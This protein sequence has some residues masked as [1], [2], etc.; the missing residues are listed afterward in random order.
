MAFLSLSLFD[1]LGLAPLM[2][3]L[4]WWP[5]DF[6][7]SFS[8]WDTSWNAWNCPSGSVIVDRGLIQQYEVS[9]SRTLNDILTLAIYSDNPTNQSFYQFHDLDTELWPSPN[10]KWFQ[11]SVCS[12]CGMSVGNA[13]PFRI[14]GSVS[15]FGTCLWMRLVFP[16]LPCLFSTFHLEHPSVLSRFCFICL[17]V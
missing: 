4:F 14:P 13:Y 12:G 7:V 11:W 3:V 15:R 10:N 5:G 8:N 17:N 9:L 1:T 6:P 16:N 2:N